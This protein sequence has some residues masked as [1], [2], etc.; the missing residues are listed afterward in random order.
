MVKFFDFL[1]G[2]N[3]IKSLKIFGCEVIFSSNFYQICAKN[4]QKADKINDYLL[5]EGFLDQ[6]TTENENY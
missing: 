3:N 6:L 5:H 4:R 2:K 1:C